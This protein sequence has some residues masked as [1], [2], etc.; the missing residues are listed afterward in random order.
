M[1]AREQKDENKSWQI[2]TTWGGRWVVV[3]G[4]GDDIGVERKTDDWRGGEKKQM[5]SGGRDR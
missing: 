4:R 5:K 3:A 2:K 1:K